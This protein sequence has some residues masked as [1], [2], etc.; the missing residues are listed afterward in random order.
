MIPMFSYQLPLVQTVRLITFLIVHSQ[1]HCVELLEPGDIDEKLGLTSDNPFKYRISETDK[2]G[3]PI[4]IEN[5]N[6]WGINSGD[7]DFGN[8][9]YYRYNFQY[10]SVFI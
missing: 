1:G 5:D 6:G 4:I 7:D 8:E 2:N 3:K 9:F 10:R